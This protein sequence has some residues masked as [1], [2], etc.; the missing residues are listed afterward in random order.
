MGNWYTNLA[1]KN[2]DPLDVV[3]RLRALGR[4]CIVHPPQN[5]W[6]AVYDEESDKFELEVLESLALTL[7]SELQCVCVACFNADD[8]VLW[9]GIFDQGKRTTRYASAVRMFEDADEF[10]SVEEFASD[11]CRVFDRPERAQ[12]VRRIL[13]RGHGAL[14]LLRFLKLPL[15][16][17]CELERHLDLKQALGLPPASVGLGYTYVSRGELAEGMDAAQLLRT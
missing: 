6:T 12:S 9:L 4:R 14:G 10:P 17:L 2:V 15:A 16:Y 3:E 8:D 11:L 5:G 1:L 13:R 7:A